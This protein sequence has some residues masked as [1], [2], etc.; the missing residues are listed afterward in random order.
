[1]KKENPYLCWGLTAFLVICGVLVFYD[2]FFQDSMIIIYIK[3][4]VEILAPVSYGFVLAYVLTPVVNWFERKLLAK[5]GLYR[6]LHDTQF[7]MD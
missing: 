6:R 5:N 2:I 4:L 3:Q 7:K 1:M